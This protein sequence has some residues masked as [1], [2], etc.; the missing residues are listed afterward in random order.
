MSQN[1]KKKDV[2]PRC[3]LV[4]DWFEEKRVGE[5]IYVYAVHYLGFEKGKKKVKKCYLG[6]LESYEYVS[7]LHRKE[8]LEFYGLTNPAR[9]FEYLNRLLDALFEVENL[10]LEG[11]DKLIEKMR[12][13]IE[14]LEKLKSN[15]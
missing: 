15:K 7:H 3:G 5:R 12:K 6:P 14:L 2:C 4:V 13:A 10:N 1:Q 11:V 9:I 8:G